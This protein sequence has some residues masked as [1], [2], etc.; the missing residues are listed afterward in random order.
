VR[1]ALIAGNSPDDIRADW[2]D[3]EGAGVPDAAALADTALSVLRRVEM[4]QEVIGF[5]LASAA[6]PEAHPSLATMGLEARARIRDR[7]ANKDLAS[8]VELFDPS[9]Y[10]SNMSVAENLLF[11]TPRPPR[12][13]C[14]PADE[15]GVHCVAARREPARRSP[16]GGRQGG[17]P[18]GRALRRRRAGQRS[19]RPVR[20]SSARTI[21]PS[22]RPL[23]A[24]IADGSLAATSETKRR[25]PRR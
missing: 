24:K 20:L 9:R 12:S 18:H 21:C 14:E 22:S 5:G 23:L 3:Y 16:R 6:D 15:S 25:G 2:L 4:E 8:Y 17:G 7:V 13:A 19:L 10:H 11:G 1:D